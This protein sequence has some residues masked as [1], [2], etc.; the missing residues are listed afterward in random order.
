[1]CY[2]QLKSKSGPH[3]IDNGPICKA[4]YDPKIY[5]SMGDLYDPGFAQRHRAHAYIFFMRAEAPSQ[6]L[7]SAIHEAAVCSMIPEM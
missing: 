2:V 3:S 7:H 4:H 6:I 1:M 5:L